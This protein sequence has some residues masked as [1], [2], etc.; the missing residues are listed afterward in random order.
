ML[1]REF[2]DLGCLSRALI[3]HAF[4]NV[5][6]HSKSLNQGHIKVQ[7]TALMYMLFGLDH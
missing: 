4:A 5:C 6:A 7:T 3:Y 2:L 1:P